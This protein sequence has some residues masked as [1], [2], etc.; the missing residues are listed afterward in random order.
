MKDLF[1]RI[2]EKLKKS[3]DEEWFGQVR[4]LKQEYVL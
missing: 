3:E 2:S 4:Q 1:R